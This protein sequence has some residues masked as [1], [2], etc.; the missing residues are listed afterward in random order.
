MGKA[1]SKLRPY[2]IQI[3]DSYLSG[4]RGLAPAPYFEDY[5]NS[6]SFT[7]RPAGIIGNTCSV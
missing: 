3:R 4:A 2:L 6:M 7:V 1:A 5:F